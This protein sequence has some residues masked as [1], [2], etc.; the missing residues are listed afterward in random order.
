[1]AILIR[2]SARPKRPVALQC[3]QALWCACRVRDDWIGWNRE[4]LIEKHGRV[5][6]IARSR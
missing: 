2:N 4:P 5:L 1:M 3:S 6:G